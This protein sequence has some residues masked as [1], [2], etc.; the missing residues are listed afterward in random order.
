[1][2]QSFGFL[3]AVVRTAEGLIPVENATV[4]VEGE[5]ESHVLLTDKSGMTSL[6]RL[7]A[8]P[9]AGSQ[10]AMQANPFAIYRVTTR[11]DGYYEQITEN[12]PVF[13][14]VVSVQPINMIGLSEYESNTLRPLSSTDTVT[15]DPQALHNSE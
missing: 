13:A 14:G 6:L 1:M 8:P 2:E 5:G 10:T 15:K 7:P 9:V 3:R 12:A 4:T 11:K